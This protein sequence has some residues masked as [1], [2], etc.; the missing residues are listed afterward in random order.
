MAVRTDK[1]SWYGK[2][3]LWGSCPAGCAGGFRCCHAYD[4]NVQWTFFSFKGKS[5]GVFVCAHGALPVNGA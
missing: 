5:H 3:Y 1:V 4:K 2:L